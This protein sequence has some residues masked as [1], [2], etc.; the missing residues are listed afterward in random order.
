MLCYW[1]MPVHL[2]NHKATKKLKPLQFVILFLLFNLLLALA[3]WFADQYYPKKEI[4][5]P[6]FWKLFVLFSLLTF[7]IFITASWRMSLSNK[8]SGQAILGT[9][10]IKLLFCMVLAFIYLSN[11]DVDPTKFLLNFFYLYFFHTVFAIYCLL[12][13]LRNQNLK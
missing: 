6:A 10:T 3:P 8:A 4:L 5:L 12:R 11:Y 7:L 2:S 9:V 1:R 13:N